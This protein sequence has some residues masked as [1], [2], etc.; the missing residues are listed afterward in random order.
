MHNA[1]I[2]HYGHHLGNARY[3]LLTRGENQVA[4][5]LSI[6]DAIRAEKAG[7]PY[8]HHALMDD[9]QRGIVY[10]AWKFHTELDA[11]C[12]AYKASYTREAIR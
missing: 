12:E 9:I 11:A 7:V 10:E 8:L 5:P 4:F 3:F 1:L 2:V 6:G